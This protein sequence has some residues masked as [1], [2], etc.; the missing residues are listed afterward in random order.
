MIPPPQADLARS[1]DQIIDHVSSLE[2]LVERVNS[3][4]ALIRVKDQ[5]ARPSTVIR[6]P[7]M[8]G[9]T[10]DQGLLQ[11]W[12][13]QV[14]SSFSGSHHMFCNALQILHDRGLRNELQG[15]LQ[16]ADEREKSLEHQVRI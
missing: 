11:R 9:I 6:R 13:L 12:S 10:F 5:Q 2:D 16:A 1:N 4:E 3:S 8:K 14:L 7:S 15:S